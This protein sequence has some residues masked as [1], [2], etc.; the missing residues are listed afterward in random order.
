MCA[1]DLDELPIDF[2]CPECWFYNSMTYREARL[3]S[4]IICRGCK[5]A[6]IPD[7]V[8]GELENVRMTIARTV[9]ALERTFQKLS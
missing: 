4:P 6:L 9:S 7:D 2:P 8:L 3:A 5:N 1:F